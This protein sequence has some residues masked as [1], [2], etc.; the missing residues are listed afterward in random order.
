MEEK[1]Y[2]IEE[3]KDYLFMNS[4]LDCDG[5]RLVKENHALDGAIS[6]IEDPHDGIGAT[7]VRDRER[8]ESFGKGLNYG[9]N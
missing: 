7:I 1:T 9:K 6:S 3:I 4:L 5:N 8:Q 2:T